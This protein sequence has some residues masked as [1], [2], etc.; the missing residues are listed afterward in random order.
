LTVH[1][2]YWYAQE[3]KWQMDRDKESLVHQLITQILYGQS[4]LC[5]I[6]SWKL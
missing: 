6:Q 3:N 2:F 4:L 5:S 1:I